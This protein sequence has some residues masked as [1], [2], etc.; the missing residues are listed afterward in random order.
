MLMFHL[1]AFIMFQ[2]LAVADLCLLASGEETVAHFAEES[3]LW[4]QELQT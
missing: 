3:G 1:Q 2:C 4:N